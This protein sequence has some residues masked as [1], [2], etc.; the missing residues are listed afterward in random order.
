MLNFKW[1]ALA[2]L[3]LR[4]V[5]VVAQSDEYVGYPESLEF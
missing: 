2:L 4:A 3:A 5:A 1:S